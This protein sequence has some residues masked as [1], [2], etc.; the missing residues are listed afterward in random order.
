M[1]GQRPLHHSLPPWAQYVPAESS[2]F[3]LDKEVRTRREVLLFIHL[4]AVNTFCIL[5]FVYTLH[6]FG[7][8]FILGLF[9]L[10]NFY[11]PDTECLSS[12]TAENS[13]V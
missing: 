2:D 10:Y 1:S 6:T 7:T 9:M 3:P 8:G 12:L 4:S 5:C 11:L 13:Y